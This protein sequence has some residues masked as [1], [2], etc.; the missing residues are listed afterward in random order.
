[1]S[2]V[3]PS[4]PGRHPETLEDLSGGRLV[5]VVHIMRGRH[6]IFSRLGVLE[7]DNGSLSLQDAKG[8]VLFDVPVTSIEARPRRRIA[9]YQTFFEI[10]AADRWWNLVAWAPNKFQ[11][12]TTTQLVERSRAREVVPLLP[13]VSEDTYH[14]LTK[15][16][17]RHQILWKECWLAVLNRTA[18]PGDGARLSP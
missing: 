16:P 8:A 6:S 18:S 12:R 7:L 13:N 2:E 17:V 14:L 15:N 4:G 5:S 10:R 1:M 11:R 3:P 9:V